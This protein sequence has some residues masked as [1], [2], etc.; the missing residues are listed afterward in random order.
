MPTDPVSPRGAAFV[1]NGRE[2]N[3]ALGDLGTLLPLMLGVLT[4]GGVSP[5]PVLFGFAAFYLV[6]A[7]YYRLPIPVQPMKAVAAMLLTVG[8]STSELAIGGMIIGLVMLVLG[9]TGWIG[10]LR[11][12]IPQS[13]LAGL[14]LGLGVMLALA[15]LSLMAEQAWLAGVTLAVL[16]VAMRIPG[17]PS[18]LLALLVAVGLGIPQWGQGPDL[19]M[20][21]QGMFP[22]TGWPGVESFER[23]MSMLVLPQLSLTVTNAIVLTALV[24]GDYFGERAAHVTPARLSVTTGLANLLLSPLGALPMCHGAGGLAAHYRFGARSGTA[25]LLL[26]LGLLGVACL[27]T[28]W[29]LAM[30]AA[31][32]VAGLGALLLVAAWQLAVTKRL[33]DSKPSCWPV[34][35]ATAVATVALD[36]FW[37]LVAGGVSEWAR[38]SWRRRRH[39]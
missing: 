28:S 30:L 14:Q 21:G 8:M 35:A 19:A 25:P 38:V 37:G 39:A 20:A 26:G 23:A 34:I 22:L 33:Y 18:V 6:T 9:V 29:G 7:F 3:G 17:C 36:P 11:R 16:L 24:A 12:L 32:P 5:G 31:I 4:V 15:S 27:P 10:H 1:F 13:V 2:L